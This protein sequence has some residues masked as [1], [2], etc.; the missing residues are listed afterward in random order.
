MIFL[1]RM[2]VK[3]M[4]SEQSGNA[5][6][7]VSRLFIG[8][9]LAGFVLLGAASLA[10]AEPITQ[11]A[12][13]GQEIFKQKCS[14]CH[15]IG[16]G[17]LVGPDLQ[18]VT[19]R[20]DLSWIKNFISAPDKI[21]ASGD[22]TAAQLLAENN[23]IRMPNLGLSPAEVDA[24]VAFLENS[25]TEKSAPAATPQ[26]AAAP[27]TSSGDPVRGEKLF[28]GAISL[29]NG[30][31]NCIACHSVAG[32]VAL[33]GGT[34][35]PDLTYVF[36]RYGAQGLV[37]ALNTL[38]FPTMQGVFVNRPLS[39]QDQADLNAYFEKANQQ[40]AASKPVIGW[41]WGAGI[42]GAL[43][44]FGIL[45]IYWPRQRQSLAER[46]RRNS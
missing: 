28:N 8:L 37:S 33:G 9:L 18:D 26:A 38:P 30:G 6:S 25:N 15:T 22:P 11:T 1:M 5:R 10:T 29:K 42:T 46:L 34:L 14:G 39:Q 21:F 27:T 41:F 4:R 44:L 19:Q 24:L 13:Q 17:K 7:V 23:N 31:P 12:E 32:N 45:L 16:G 36:T 2:E 35:G 3:L 40:P 43:I 20:R